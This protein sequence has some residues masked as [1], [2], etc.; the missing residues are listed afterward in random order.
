MSEKHSLKTTQE[1]FLMNLIDMD[2]KEQIKS[3]P[4]EFRPEVIINYDK[5]INGAI[6]INLRFNSTL[7]KER[8]KKEN[9]NSLYKN[10]LILFTDGLSR[11]QF[12]RKLPK[13][14]QFLSKFM[15]YKGNSFR[16]N[17]K[18]NVFH[19][20]E[21][22]KYHSML[23]TTMGNEI[24]MIYGRKFDEDE[25]YD[26]NKYFQENGYITGIA[27]EQC[28]KDSVPAEWCKKNGKIIP[29][30][31]SYHDHEFYGLACDPFHGIG[32][33]ADRGMSSPYRRCLYGKMIIEHEIEYAKQ[34]FEKY[35]NNQKY[36]RL[37][38]L[39]SHD[40]GTGQLIN[41]DDEI[42]FNFLDYIFKNNYLNNGALLFLSDHGN[43][44]NRIFYIFND[45]MLER[46]LPY[47]YIILQDDNNKTYD[48]QYEYIIR[49]QQTF[50]YPY[51]IY[52]T[53]SNII[54]GE[55]YH[56]IKNKSETLDTPK[57]K[58]GKSL[59]GYINPTRDCAKLNDF[60]QNCYC[61]L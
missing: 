43:T 11:V 40:N 21:F 14:S 49:N 7:S 53:L 31:G 57:S 58:R 51:D 24:P 15:K 45:Y 36:F 1:T 32:W 39:D 6:D 13:T 16:Y 9:K 34:F 41:F 3:I 18:K 60:G 33:K 50:I 2:N 25:A 52:N 38:I 56:L 19:G 20:F 46:F 4:E 5:D 37:I 54:Y 55:K 44:T 28:G 17:G 47:L 42:L 27:N 22:L 29:R 10:I 12:I 48:K 26:I 30:K 61:K 59:L 35:K 8:K 23:L